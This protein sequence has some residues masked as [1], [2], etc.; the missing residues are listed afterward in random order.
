MNDF[1]K[2]MKKLREFKG[3]VRTGDTVP[4]IEV[5][6]SDIH[7]LDKNVL[8]LGGFP[9]GR[10]IEIYGKPSCGKTT[11][12]EHIIAAVQKKGGTATYYNLE[13]T[14]D[15]IWGAKAGIDNS[16]L[17]QPE[18]RWGEEIFD[19][20]TSL[21]DIVDIIVLDSLARL[22]SKSIV[23]RTMEDGKMVAANAGMNE[24]GFGHITSGT[25]EK[26]GKMKT[27]KISE[28]KTFILVIN[29]I[30]D[31]IGVMYGPTEK[32]TGGWA[33]QHDF[34][35]RLHMSNPKYEKDGDHHKQRVK[36]RCT[37]HKLAP[38]LREC[39]FYIT[40]DN[41]LDQ[42]E[43][44]IILNEAIDKGIIEQSGSW[45][46]CKYFEDGKLQ[47]KPKFDLW[48]EED[49]NRKEFLAILKGN[50]P[51]EKSKS[52]TVINLIEENK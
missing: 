27:P 47:G 50:K 1:D 36:I 30:R 11:L 12:A 6:K 26:N 10:I 24:M 16:K 32:T 45:L 4:E 13:G 21:L 28:T 42:D 39:E 41:K 46:K 5:V 29:Q 44:S 7:D 20:V 9:R 18:C 23:T 8:G 31:N 37:K 48:L 33:C 35:I 2:A 34:T 17:I 19:Q 51:V 14:Y 15:P 3:E 22:R 25:Y 40:E 43:G 52:D 49:D 38:P